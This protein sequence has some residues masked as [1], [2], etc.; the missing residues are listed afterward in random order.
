MNK[1]IYDNSL[2]T[3][4]KTSVT[5]AVPTRD[6]VHSHFAYSLCQLVKTTVEH[7][8]NV[9]T[10]F[11]SSTI[12]LN[13]RENL[14]EM[15]KECNS[16]YILWLDS[17]M[18][19]PPTTI[20]RLLEHNKDIVGCNYMKRTLPLKTVAYTN[21]NDWD[22]WVRMEPKNDLIE[23]EGIGLGCILMKVN[24]FDNLTKPYFEFKYREDSEDWYGEDF[25]LIGKLRNQGF[26]IHVDTILSMDIKHMG[27]YAY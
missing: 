24:I 15:A 4:K 20:I 3:T 14:I 8:I 19:F 7:G 12:L 17:D 9:F 11:D 21:V 27:I 1:S 2:W 6:M 26:K 22:S 18:V 25:M 13:Q 10:F 23:V 16:E 5:I